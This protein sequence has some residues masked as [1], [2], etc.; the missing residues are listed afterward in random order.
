MASTPESLQRT[1]DDLCDH[2]WVAGHPAARLALDRVDVPAELGGDHHAVF[3]WR[4]RFANEFLVDIRPVDLGGVEEGDAEVD[5]SADDVEHL[6]PVGSVAV[7]AGHA[8]AAQPDRGNLQAGTEDA[9]LHD[10]SLLSLKAPVC[11][12]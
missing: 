10:Q 7:T 8:H 2:C 5:G 6:R 1:L 11:P 9:L 3:Y 4:E 12:S